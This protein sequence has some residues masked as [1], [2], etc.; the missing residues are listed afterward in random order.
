LGWGF[1]SNINEAALFGS[2]ELFIDF[3][4]GSTLRFDMFS[5]AEASKFV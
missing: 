1:F 2:I 3:K 5:T 4:A